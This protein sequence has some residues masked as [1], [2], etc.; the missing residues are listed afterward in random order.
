MNGHDRVSGTHRDLNKPP[1]DGIQRRPAAKSLK[2][3]L[4]T[5]ESAPYR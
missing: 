1:H 2:R 5:T 4:A 3:H